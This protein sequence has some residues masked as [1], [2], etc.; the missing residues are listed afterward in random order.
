MALLGGREVTKVNSDEEEIRYSGNNSEE[1]AYQEIKDVFGI[2]PVRI[3][4][5]SAEVTFSSMEL[6]ENLRTAFL[7]YSK[8]GKVISYII[9]VAY[10]DGAWGSDIEDEIIKEY[11]YRLSH[12]DAVVTEYKI[13]DTG[14][15]EYSAEFDYKDVHYQLT[16]IMEEEEL[17]EILDN[18]HF[19]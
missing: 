9:N 6:D 3:V 12:A 18:L 5:R 15:T 2:D 1:D 10:D 4:Q 14:G 13:Q 8:N 16:G 11:P 7:L 17:E 19:L